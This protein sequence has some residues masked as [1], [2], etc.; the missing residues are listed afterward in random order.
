VLERELGD[1]SGAGIS[2]SAI[3]RLLADQDQPEL[4]IIF[5]KQSINLREEI[6]TDLRS[7]SPDLQQSYTDT[8][9]ADYRTLA[10]LLLQQGRI[11]EA[12]RVLD[13]LKVQEL[14]DY[15]DGV[16]S[17]EDSR[18][19]VS[20]L[21]PETAIAALHSDLVD[22]AIQN[23]QELRQL[24][25]PSI[26][27]TPEELQR[28]DQLQAEEDVL[29]QAFFGFVKSPEVQQRLAELRVKDPAELERNLSLDHLSDL[30]DNLAR[31]NQ[32]AVLLYPLV[33]D[34]RLELI[35]VTPNTP[36]IRRTS[37]ISR[38]DLNRLVG[39]LRY[40]LEAPGREAKAPAQEL[41]DVLLRPFAADLEAAGAK[42]LIYAPDRALRYVPLATLHDGQQWLVETYRIH[43]ITAASLDD[44]DNPPSDQPSILAGAFT[45][46]QYDITVGEQVYPF[47]GLA[48]TARELDHLDSLVSADQFTGYR[49][50]DFSPAAIRQQ[51][52]R[53]TIIHLATHAQFEPGP[54]EHSFILF[55]NGEIKTL[56]DLDGGWLTLRNADLVVLSACETAL[57]SAVSQEGAEILGLGYVMQQK[58]GARATLASLW[59]VDDGGTE[60][61]M[62]R[63]YDA[64]LR[65]RLSKAAALRE[66]QL[67]FIQAAEQSQRGFEV[68]YNTKG[69]AIDPTDLSHPYY[70]AP[71]ILIGNGL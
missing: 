32:D 40:A 36:P 26:P 43:N 41:Y 17:S 1:V 70:W 63:F 37:P 48:H 52:N 69:E 16:R 65:G 59:K 19:G 13:L 24:E 14:D 6:R 66:A 34:D 39:Q 54:P 57:D 49:D 2:M 61:L 58:A 7:L 62:E 45:Q 4:A 15:L 12:L 30:Q 42:T 28:L 44:L 60:A 11:V 67:S 8:V 18:R 53:H 9:A 10:D 71:F 20:N 56:T 21:P 47:T 35:L 25:R 3:G 5:Y 50:Q 68:V 31:I 38:A 23:G 51:A 29:V 22:R 27:L 64:L 55:G 46:G 33:L